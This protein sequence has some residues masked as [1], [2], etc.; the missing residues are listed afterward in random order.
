MQHDHERLRTRAGGGGKFARARRIR[1]YPQTRPQSDVIKLS[2]GGERFSRAE[3]EQRD[4]NESAEETNGSARQAANISPHRG[5]DEKEG[6]EN[7]DADR[8]RKAQASAEAPA[9]EQQ[10]DHAAKQKKH[11]R[12]RLP[13]AQSPTDR[14]ETQQN[15]TD[16][17]GPPRPAVADRGVRRSAGTRERSRQPVNRAPEE[18]NA[19]PIPNR[20]RNRKREHA[21]FIRSRGRTRQRR[22]R[23]GKER[24]IIVVPAI[25]LRDRV[26]VDTVSHRPGRAKETVNIGHAPLEKGGPHL[27]HRPE[28][29]E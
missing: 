3:D 26:N 6:R 13:A 14:H 29:E 11:E 22:H 28:A 2:I 23:D 4:Q 5:M 25:R 21:G 17:P 15:R 10:G 9:F 20:D 1:P 16:A 27:R 24:R 7:L 8:P 19:E 18:T 12:V